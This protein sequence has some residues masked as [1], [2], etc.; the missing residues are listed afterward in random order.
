[1]TEEEFDAIADSFRDPRVW[2]KGE[3]GEWVKDSIRAFD[4]RR[5][6]TV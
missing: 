6:A 5:G 3:D 4:A 1:M 2:V